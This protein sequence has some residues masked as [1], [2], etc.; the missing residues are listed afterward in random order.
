MYFSCLYNSFIGLA[1]H[2]VMTILM[3]YVAQGQP[4]MGIVKVKIIGLAL[5]LVFRTITY[6]R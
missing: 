2:G 1:P 5:A 3:Y 6:L 4:W